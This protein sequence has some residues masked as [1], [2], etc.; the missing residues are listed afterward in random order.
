MR[1]DTN[2]RFFEVDAVKFF[3]IICMILDITKIGAGNGA[4]VAFFIK[5]VVLGG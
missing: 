1:Q 2:G 5:R 3:A 4:A